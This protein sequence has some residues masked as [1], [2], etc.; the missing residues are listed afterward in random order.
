MN[1]AKE[2]IP[3]M[4]GGATGGGAVADPVEMEL[5]DEDEDE[6][7]EATEKPLGHGKKG[8]KVFDIKDEDVDAELSVAVLRKLLKRAL[9]A[10][11]E[12]CDEREK[13]LKRR[14]NCL[15]ANGFGAGILPSNSGAWEK[16]IVCAILD[17]AD[18]DVK[19]RSERS[20]SKAGRG[21]NQRRDAFIEFF[22]GVADG[23]WYAHIENEIMARRGINKR[24]A[25]AL[26]D[27]GAVNYTGLGAMR[28]A[29]GDQGNAKKRNTKPCAI[30]PPSAAGRV[31]KDLDDVARR[32]GLIGPTTGEKWESDYAKLFPST[33]ELW[34]Y[35]D[36]F[37]AAPDSGTWRNPEGPQDG[38]IPMRITLA[39]DEFPCESGKGGTGLMA[40]HLKH[41]DPRLKPSISDSPQQSENIQTAV[42]YPTKTRKRLAADAAKRA[43]ET[44]EGEGETDDEADNVAN[45]DVEVRHRPAE[46]EPGDDFEG[47][48]DAVADEGQAGAGL[49]AT[50]ILRSKREQVGQQLGPLF[51]TAFD[52]EARSHE[53][54]S[55]VPL[56]CGVCCDKVGQFEAGAFGG[57]TV[58]YFLCNLCGCPR[59]NAGSG[60][61]GGCR[62]CREAGIADE[63]TH[64]DMATEPTREYF[65]AQAAALAE[66]VGPIPS[67]CLPRWRNKAEAY[68]IAQALGLRVNRSTK[69]ESIE[70]AIREYCDCLVVVGAP[71]SPRH[72]D[73]APDDDV[74]R[75]A[76]RWASAAG[77]SVPSRPRSKVAWKRVRSELKTR[78]IDMER[79]LLV[80]QVLKFWDRLEPEDRQ[81]QVTRD[82][83]IVDPSRFI[84]CSMHLTLRVVLHVTGLL[85]AWPLNADRGLDETE[86]TRRLDAATE[87][88]RKCLKSESFTHRKAKGNDATPWRP[89]TKVGVFSMPAWRA[90]RIARTELRYVAADDDHYVAVDEDQG[91][92]EVANVGDTLP[93]QYDYA[94][95][96]DDDIELDP[97]AVA[98]LLSEVA[99]ILLGDDAELPTV[100]N[101]LQ[102]LVWV[103]GVINSKEWEADTDM[104]ARF[105][106]HADKLREHLVDVWG[107]SVITIYLH[108]IIAGHIRDM[109]LFYGPICRH[110][111]EATERHGGAIVV[112]YKRHSQRGGRKGGAKGGLAGKCDG[113]GAWVGRQT[114]RST[115]R[116]TEFLDAADAARKEH[117][118]ARR[119]R[120]RALRARQA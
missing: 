108:D 37:E 73:S 40:A 47:A 9:Q 113:M 104:P 2:T 52:A 85:Y 74:H 11:R 102:E 80:R 111:N 45:G 35:Q 43:R 88:M 91:S 107:S 114:I 56:Q 17:D 87:L 95:D 39:A 90:K 96:V 62:R 93:P 75:D 54:E 109:M 25:A 76:A 33:L 21:R 51:R 19:K 92:L 79:L 116:A 29:N 46:H 89:G 15:R 32:Y 44:P 55:A 77:R 10:G 65:V 8:R 94:E 30:P 81:R 38:P 59:A 53:D 110:S 4:P 49:E 41:V 27:A 105:Q 71:D 72:V 117:Q 86:I 118:T 20:A 112:R 103:L 97:K 42:L 101:F 60:Q 70:A 6:E 23:A 82:G 63:C 100:L 58:G 64:W 7:E 69:I 120:D 13:D 22:K 28:A 12:L 98:P 16:G 67:Q 26:V 3:T 36:A 68:A 5:E 119:R 34:K 14:K 83:H 61:P 48:F 99:K 18:A 78:L 50:G 115:G 24:T 1:E 66:S 84:D 106:R 31:N 57:A